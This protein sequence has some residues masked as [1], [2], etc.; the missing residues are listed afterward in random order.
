MCVLKV[1]NFRIGVNT[2]DVAAGPAVFSDCNQVRH[3]LANMIFTIDPNSF[4]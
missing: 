3:H 2:L 4:W 1:S